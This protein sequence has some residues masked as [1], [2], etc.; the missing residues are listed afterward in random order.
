MSLNKQVWEK[1]NKHENVSVFKMV[2]LWM[3]GKQ[4]ITLESEALSGHLFAEIAITIETKI[5]YLPG[6][7]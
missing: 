5:S 4:N 3:E 2:T 7:F 6:F 1:K